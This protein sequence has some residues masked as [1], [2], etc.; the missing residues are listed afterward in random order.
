EVSADHALRQTQAVLTEAGAQLYHITV[1]PLGLEDLTHLVQDTLH[2][3][4]ADARPLASLLQ[5]KTDGNPF[6]VI[7]FLKTLQ[8]EGCVPFDPDRRCWTYDT[9]AI[10]TALI[11][12]NVVELMSHKI[13]RLPSRTQRAVT[14]AACVGHRCDLHTLAIVSEQ[15]PEAT[16]ADLQPAVDAGL[17][18]LISDPA[19]A[20]SAATYAFLHDRVQQAAYAQIADE[21]KQPLHL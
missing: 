3:D 6:F 17:L 10:A 14:L 21:H 18:F 12:D 19:A 1:P 4:L 20:G 7:H 11:T 5:H 16:A 15:T 8:Q 9:D 2:G 13:Q